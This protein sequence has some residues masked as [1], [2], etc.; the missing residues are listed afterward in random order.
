MKISEILQEGFKSFET[1]QD[2]ILT[3]VTARRVRRVRKG[4]V[5]RKRKCPHGFKLDGTRCVRQQARERIR[6][7]RAGRKAARR[8]KAARKRNFKKSIRLRQRRHLKRNTR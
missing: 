1:E 8:G 7:K 4:K 2:T 5:V 6:R 3:E